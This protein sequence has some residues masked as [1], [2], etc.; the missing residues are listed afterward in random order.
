[1][2]AFAALFHRDGRPA[3][4]WPN[5]GLASLRQR[6]VS[7]V[8]RNGPVMLAGTDMEA[9][10]PDTA[11]PVLIVAADVRLDNR[12][13]IESRLGLPPY[14]H[15]PD[16][17]LIAALYDQYGQD[18]TAYLLGDFA[19]LLWD[20]KERTLFGARDHSGV[21][22]FYYHSTQRLF[23]AATTIGTLLQSGVSPAIDDAGIADFV[24]GAVA[25]TTST[26]YRHIRRL[27]PGHNILVT[28]GDVRIQ[29]Y[30]ELTPQ[31]PPPEK[32]WTDHF[33][34]LFEQAVACRM[35]DASTGVLLSGGL[36][37]SSI[38][39]TASRIGEAHDRPPLPSLSMTFDATPGWSDGPFLQSV[40]QAGR[41]P[42]QYLPSDDHDPLR[43][44]D[45]T[46]DEQAGLYLAYNH[47]ASRRLYH[48]AG[49]AGITSLLDGHGGD[50]VVSHGFG[51]LNELAMA[52]R[53][54][55]LWRESNGVARLFGG[56]T[57]HVAAPHLDHV[58]AIRK[59]R[60]R[61]RRMSGSSLAVSPGPDFTTAL[62]APD[63]ARRTAIRARQEAIAPSR[64]AYQTEQQRHLAILTGPHQPYAF[65]ILDRAAAAAGIE[66][67]F[68]FYDRRLVDFCLSLPS[69]AKLAKGYPR[70][71]LRDAMA[72]TLPEPVR[73]RRDKFDFT[74]QFRAGMARHRTHLQSVLDGQ[75][76]MLAPYL[77]LSVARAAI[78][79][80]DQGDA[81]G[82]T[83]LF[84]AWRI[85]LL[86]RWLARSADSIPE[87]VSACGRTR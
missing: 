57:W 14:P 45:T 44:I 38:A 20:E 8:A 51:R 82:T 27:P 43:D 12:T 4:R 36:D 24:A 48:H 42:A 3:D 11:R 65:E 71:I 68:P 66:L 78:A 19:F 26:L 83:P 67:L 84:A 30:W 5:S 46:L 35:A 47:G 85:A 74:G 32:D 39:M 22:P 50:E 29:R 73:L 87:T 10:Y 86:G 18:C 76:D 64:S 70:A 59:I 6:G 60:Q 28:E 81:G 61:W 13:E 37:S 16:A 25:D 58:M 40:V 52:H 23:M 56:S 62:V 21:R 17:S 33:R 15:L 7:H 49:R 79:R 9:P 75:A 69:N 34:H 2:T 55:S 53:W 80:L 72:G 77:D 63:L 41:F 1:M 31:A 54:A